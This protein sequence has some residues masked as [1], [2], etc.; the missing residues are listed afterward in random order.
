MKM[1]RMTITLFIALWLALGA[2]ALIAQEHF[3]TLTGIVV[4]IDGDARKWLEVKSE[5][6]GVSMNFR[7]RG[8]TIYVPYRYP[9][10]GEKVR[11]LY[12]T[13]KGVS[14]ATKILIFSG[15][16]SGEKKERP[17]ATDEDED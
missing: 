6:D 3:P 16:K 14:I 5:T 1:Q 15:E 7:I 2:H 11:I 12:I 9:T 10:I 8:D 17:E 4:G 13:E